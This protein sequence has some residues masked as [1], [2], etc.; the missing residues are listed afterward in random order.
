[1]RGKS[2]IIFTALCLLGAM[3]LCSA[4]DTSGAKMEFSF[5][6]DKPSNYSYDEKT[7]YINEDM[8]TLTMYGNLKVDSG[9]VSVHVVRK[10]DEQSL[11][12][13]NYT[14]DSSFEILLAN[15]NAGDEY[16]LQVTTTESK[17]VKL[18]VTS[19]AKMVPDKEKPEKMNV[20]KRYL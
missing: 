3:V 13:N 6:S 12:Q 1:M 16:V 10:A 15:L 7:L 2:A 17:K 5:S 14:K 8:E 4:C 11:W 18:I 20:K 19:N 9:Q